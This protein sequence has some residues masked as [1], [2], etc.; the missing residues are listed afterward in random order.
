MKAIQFSKTGE[1]EV[2]HLVELETPQP[3][4][5]QVLIK[6]AVVGVN[7]GETMQRA[8]TYP[9][10][11]P[12][13]IIPG[14]EV[15]G[16]IAA[17][18]SGVSSLSIGT[19]VAAMIPT[20]VGGYAEYCVVDAK[21]VIT[22][23]DEID[24]PQATAL[25]SQGL[26]AYY[27][28]NL[29]TI[30]K[31]GNSV[32]IH[33]AAGGVGSIAVQLAKIMGA[34]KVIGTASSRHK[35]DLIQN[36]GADIGI[37]YT[38]ANWVEDVKEATNNNGVDIILDS[39]GGEISKQSFQCLAPFGRMIVYGALSLQI[40]EFTAQQIMQLI[41][42]NQ[43][44]AGFALPNLIAAQPKLAEEGFR[45]LLQYFTSGKLNIVVRNTFPLAEATTA[46]RQIEERQTTGK[47]VLI[48]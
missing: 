23:S 35:L 48:V 47:V 42:G 34:G 40:A 21:D 10:S 2:L 16:T 13:P 28:L 30:L 15:A 7:F 44:I 37:N 26:T 1:P 4:E 45:A 8:G 33:A 27:L 14:S 46:H 20:Q 24:F 3:G 11:L 36:L 5:N 32:L 38:Q 31:P 19:R 12:L 25:L 17:L 41:Y 22:L 43:L 9:I 29:A 39:V 18:G 6:V